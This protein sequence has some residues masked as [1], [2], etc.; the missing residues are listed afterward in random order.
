MRALKARTRLVVRAKRMVNVKSLIAGLKPPF[1]GCGSLEVIAKLTRWARAA[2]SVRGITLGMTLFAA[3][4]CADAITAPP[5][6][7]EVVAQRLLPSV[8]DAHLRLVP[9]IKNAGVRDRIAFDMRKID[10]AL[11]KGDA[12]RARY[13]LRLVGNTLID[14]RKV[15]GN[16]KEDSADVVAIALALH[17]VSK[18]LGGDFDITLIQ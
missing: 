6:L 13:H 9:A 16:A 7:G 15:F 18:A 12:D 11:G 17:A 5:S 10:D 14:Y 4:G 3:V 2:G 8:M 1:L